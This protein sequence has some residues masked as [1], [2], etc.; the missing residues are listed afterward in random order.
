MLICVLWWAMGRLGDFGAGQPM[1]GVDTAEG[2]GCVVH[3]G[4]CGGPLDD[5]AVQY[6][7]SLNRIVSWGPLPCTTSL[8]KSTALLP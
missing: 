7:H 6:S 8:Y 5:M 1:V 4:W 3:Y 2:I